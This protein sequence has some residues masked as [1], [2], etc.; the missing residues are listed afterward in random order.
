M[1]VKKGQHSTIIGLIKLQ[2]YLF[3]EKKKT[4][5]I[6]LLAGSRLNH[7][8]IGMLVDRRAE[9]VLKSSL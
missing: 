2:T 4:E 7:I 5:S 8:M 9:V 3:P 1:G 6:F